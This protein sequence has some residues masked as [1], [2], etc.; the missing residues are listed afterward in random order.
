[1]GLAQR[2]QERTNEPKIHDVV[3]CLNEQD[4]KAVSRKDPMA[5]AATPNNADAD[6]QANERTVDWRGEFKG[7]DDECKHRDLQDL[8]HEHRAE[9]DPILRPPPGTSFGPFPIKRHQVG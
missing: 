9:G 7:A 3:P 1:M 4:A 6:Q 5:E 8:T 2:H